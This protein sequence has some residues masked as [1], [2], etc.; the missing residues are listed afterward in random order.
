MGTLQAPLSQWWEG[1][2]TRDHKHYVSY[3][4]SCHVLS[5][6]ST[7]DIGS[8]ANLASGWHRMPTG[9]EQLVLS[10]SPAA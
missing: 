10:H 3:T 2:G 1:S 6:Y 5:V 7:Q 9:R 4:L 8:E